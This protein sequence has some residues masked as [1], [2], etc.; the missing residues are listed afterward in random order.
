MYTKI[1]DRIWGKFRREDLNQN[2]KLLYIYT[3]SCP[4]RTLLGI[5][6]LPLSYV[7]E[8]LGF[9]VPVTK[10]LMLSLENKKM[11]EYD[12]ANSLI[13]IK[14]FLE[15][16]EIPNRNVE[17]KAVRLVES[18][19]PNTLLFESLLLETAPYKEKLPQLFETVLKRYCEQFN[20]SYEK[21]YTIW[22]GNTEVSKQKAEYRS[23][24]SASSKQKGSGADA[25]SETDDADEK[26]CMKILNEC[27]SL[28]PKM[29]ACQEDRTLEYLKALSPEVVQEALKKAERHGAKTWVYLDTIL[30]DLRSR[31][32]QTV[33]A[34]RAD[35]DRHQRVKWMVGD[36]PSAPSAGAESLRR[37][38]D[39]MDEFLDK[40]GGEQE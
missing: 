27:R 10:K 15:C 6:K 33:E 38:L 2:E 37:E 26:R 13:L 30:E 28:F 16:N 22:Y 24:K 20:K 4:H 25:P 21:E 19:L 11:I 40:H 35:Q 1:H 32:I 8:D 9:S 34:M 17:K 5:F 29:T 31:G 18:G 23:Q 14:N 3:F 39:W 12:T 7:A 36:G